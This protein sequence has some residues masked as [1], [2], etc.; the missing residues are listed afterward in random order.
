MATRCKPTL[1]HSLLVLDSLLADQLNMSLFDSQDKSWRNTSSWSASW[2]TKTKRCVRRSSVWSVA[3]QMRPQPIM[4][5]WLRMRSWS[6]RWERSAASFV[7]A[8]HPYPED[9]LSWEHLSTQ[10]VV[11]YSILSIQL[12]SQLKTVYK[13]LLR[14]NSEMS[15]PVLRRMSR[16]TSL[17]ELVLYA[18][19]IRCHAMP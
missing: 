8:C 15:H 12:S 19:G 7:F 11:G 2:R 4:T 14:L 13:S 6:R 10:Q 1:I 18:V 9:E 16:F 17:Y 3:W 5:S